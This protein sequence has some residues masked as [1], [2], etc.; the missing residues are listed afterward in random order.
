MEATELGG[1]ASG[2]GN[3]QALLPGSLDIMQSSWKA[4]YLL[5]SGELM[6]SSSILP[7]PP[8]STYQSM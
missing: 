8:Q 5:Q 4:G 2:S 6:V 7:Y 3:R 1:A